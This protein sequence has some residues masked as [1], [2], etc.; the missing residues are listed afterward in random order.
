[1]TRILIVDDKEENIYY[2]RALLTGHGYAVDSAQHGAEALVK[3]WQSPPDLV[4]SDLLMPL[5]DGYT[6]LRL[7]KTDGHL[8]RVPFIIHTA[9]YTNPEDERLALSLGADAFILKPVE[10]DEFIARLRRV[11]NRVANAKPN[12]P[13]IPASDEKE[14]LKVYNEILIRK[15]EEKT[16]QLE[17]SNRELQQDIAE[18]NKVEEELRLVNSAMQQT[19]ES[20]MITDAELDLPGPR[21]I[22]VNP[23]FTRMT[24][25]MA[26]ETIGKT[27]RIL[28]G[29]NTDK[30]IL[31]RLRQKLKCGEFF[32][33]ETINY[34]K[35]GTE[36]LQE[37]KVSPLRDDSENITHYLAVQ[38]DITERKLA[39][40]ALRGSEDRYRTL[41]TS[42]DE[43]FCVIEVIFDKRKKPVDY[44][45]LEVN[46]TFE[47]QTRLIG[48]VGKR[49]RELVPDIESHRIEIYG[50]VA[51]TGESIRFVNE[52]KL[53]PGR[54]FNVYA[55]R[56]G[57]AESRKVAI[58]FDD[59][60]ERKRVEQQ[61]AE[62]AALLDNARD[63]ILVRDLEG[64]IVYW[65]NGAERV[66]GWK[67]SEA[68]GQEMEKLLYADP[69]KFKEVNRLTISL[70]EWHGEI[71]HL[72]RDRRELIVEARCTLIR[73][74]QGNPKS[75]LAINTDITEKKKIEAQLMRSQRMESI[76]T[77]AGGIAHDLNNILAPIMMSIQVLK[78]KT[79]DAQAQSILDTIEASTSRGA[80]VVRKVLSFARGLEGERI[81]IKPQQL[82]KEFAGII[83]DTFPKDIRLQFSIPNNIWVILGDPTQMHQILLNLCVNARDAMPQGGTLNISLENC[84]LDEHLAIMNLEA[85]TGRYV[86]ISVA[87]SG[88]GM[89]Q[90]VLDKIFEPFFTTKEVGKGTGLGMS[91]VMA[92]AKSHKG[93][94][95]VD[96]EPGKGTTFRVFLPA[97][98]MSRRMAKLPPAKAGLPR[99]N[100]ETILVVDD[101][102]SIRSVTKN[103]LNVFGYQ[104]L[105]A[106]NGAEAITIY[107]E[108]KNKIAVVL[109]DM[110]MP[111]M[112]GA[113]VVQALMKINPKVKII[114]VSGLHAKNNLTKVSQAKVKSFL[115]KP[116]TAETLLKTLRAI[117]DET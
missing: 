45:F 117:L 76:G 68:V 87:D 3:A 98:K 43:G 114:V 74:N 48:V 109:T 18:R 41:F 78:G 70:S 77:L 30:A 20:I 47:K 33:G 103:A 57:G 83:K 25:Y 115:R 71:K 51:L 100:G 106:A 69:K 22:F 108:H 102:A 42:I 99:G 97:L 80:D 72:T 10:P 55:C 7:W 21:I 84:V 111:V 90:E 95:N 44:R 67:R 36:Y 63:A 56:V 105:T 85:K 88:S 38:R 96:S 19:R 34:R 52:A 54:W 53:M 11:Q 104:V 66:Y 62:Q 9:T 14:L 8:K 75:V 46:P 24:G 116:Y 5:M 60:T 12:P 58:I 92:I 101:E 15:L 82:L 49:I 6:L 59:I 107:S 81:E 112:N 16:L 23:A 93:F 110:A 64:K 35:D 86:Q 32:E 2:L 27:P 39:E 73:D 91:T 4:I 31:R 17:E 37:W 65:N 29:P 40:S 26:E 61:I 94:V 113:A 79:F 50:K 89:T 1:M 28:Q 13:K